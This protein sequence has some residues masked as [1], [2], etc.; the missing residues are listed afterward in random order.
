[1]IAIIDYGLGNIRAFAN[2]YKRLNIEHCIAELP[3]QL[4]TADK[5][6]LPGVGAFDYAITLL[7]NSGMRPLL[8]KR[9]LE[10]KIPVLGIC[11][12]MQMMAESSEEG[13][14]PGL[15]WIPGQV[16]KFPESVQPLPHMGWNN[17]VIRR[18]DQILQGIDK[19]SRFYFLHSYFFQ[20][21]EEYSVATTEYQVDFTC[22]AR[23][24]NVYG[25]Q[26]H[27]EKSHDAGI[28]VLKNFALI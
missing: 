15:G 14:L 11:V 18:D 21:N 10:D 23:N 19:E 5:I 12:G 27:P 25:I 28:N 2:L 17:P 16:V 7:D 3:D 22:V 4:K 26:F 6:I 1:M 24:D 20:C 13:Q 9:V 8:E